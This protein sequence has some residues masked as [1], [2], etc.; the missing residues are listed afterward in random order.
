MDEIP[1]LRRNVM[2]KRKRYNSDDPG[3]TVVALQRVKLTISLQLNFAKALST[4]FFIRPF[5]QNVI[6]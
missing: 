6:I 2:Q 1:I 3:L 5:N 4:P